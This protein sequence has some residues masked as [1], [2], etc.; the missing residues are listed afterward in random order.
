MLEFRAKSKMTEEHRCLFKTEANMKRMEIQIP[1]KFQEQMTR[2]KP[3]GSE[4][5]LK[6]CLYNPS[7]HLQDSVG[8]AKPQAM[9]KGN[10]KLVKPMCDSLLMQ[11]LNPQASFQKF[12]WKQSSSGF[13]IESEEFGQ[14]WRLILFKEKNL[15]LRSYWLTVSDQW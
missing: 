7:L 15:I 1:L 8:L 4:L 3:Q 10:L 12:S 9:L 14:Y 6:T 11:E 5:K 13:F 2:A